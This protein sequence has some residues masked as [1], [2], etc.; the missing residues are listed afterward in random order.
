MS[1]IFPPRPRIRSK[2]KRQKTAAIICGSPPPI[3]LSARLCLPY[4]AHYPQ[5][6]I[7]RALDLSIARIWR[8]NSSRRI[9]CSCSGAAQ[10]LNTRHHGCKSDTCSWLSSGRCSRHEIETKPIVGRNGT[11]SPVQG[12]SIGGEECALLA[13]PSCTLNPSRQAPGPILNQQRQR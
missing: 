8:L 3:I 12:K 1:A 7:W 9:Q 5:K 11:W 13:W 10:P 6:R 4:F 2:D